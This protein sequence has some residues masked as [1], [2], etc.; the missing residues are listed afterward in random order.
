VIFAIYK[1]YIDPYGSVDL[2][3]LGYCEFESEDDAK[4]EF[5]HGGGFVGYLVVKSHHSHP[6]IAISEPNDVHEMF[7]QHRVAQHEWMQK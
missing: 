7:V 4:E 5:P 3:Q 2:Y 1:Q 6:S